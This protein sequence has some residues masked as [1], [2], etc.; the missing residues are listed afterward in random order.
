MSLNTVVLITGSVDILGSVQCTVQ[1]T[2][3]LEP[4]PGNWATAGDGAVTL[5]RLRLKIK[6]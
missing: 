6:F 2:R 4:E 5:A 3:V 1:C